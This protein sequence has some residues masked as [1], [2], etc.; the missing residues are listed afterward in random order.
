VSNGTQC[1]R[2]Y[3]VFDAMIINPLAVQAI[4]ED[5]AA[6]IQRQEKNKIRVRESELIR[7]LNRFRLAE[8][9]ESVRSVFELP[10]LYK[11]SCPSKSYFYGWTDTMISCIFEILRNYVEHFENEEDVDDEYG[12]ILFRQFEL[13]MNNLP[14]IEGYGSGYEGIAVDALTSQI[15]SA[16]VLELRKIGNEAAHDLAEQMKDTYYHQAI[17][18]ARKHSENFEGTF[19]REAGSEKGASVNQ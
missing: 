1:D 15:Q 5:S 14:E 12:K 8:F 3:E 6:D 11:C 13:F 7:S 2:L 18:S 9:S 19:V 4:L 16:V 10:L 17:A